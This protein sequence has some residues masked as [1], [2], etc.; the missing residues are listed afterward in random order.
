VGPEELLVQALE[1]G[2]DGG[3]SGGANVWP[4]LFVQIYE[5]TL[6]T[7]ETSIAEQGD[8]LPYLVDRADRLAQIYRVGSETITAPC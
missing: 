8:V 5:A 4:Q 7:T 1:L 2:A 6:A 3:V